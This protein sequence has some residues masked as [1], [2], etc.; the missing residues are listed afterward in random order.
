MKRISAIL[1]L[2]STQSHAITLGDAISTVVNDTSASISNELIVENEAYNSNIVASKQS[3]SQYAP[4]PYL[5]YSYSTPLST[6]LNGSLPAGFNFPTKFITGLTQENYGF[7]V[8][9]NI[10]SLPQAVRKIQSI[11][12][13]R[14][15]AKN[16]MEGKKA[17]FYYNLANVYI[18]LYR[19]EEI[20]ILQ[21]KIYE[22]AKARAIEIQKN[23]QYGMASKKDSLLSE[24]EILQAEMNLENYQNILKNAQAKYQEKFK[25][26]HAGLELVETPLFQIA[27]NVDELKEKIT[28]NQNVIALNQTAKSYKIESGIEKLNLLPKVTI[29][30]RNMFNNPDSSLG[31]PNYMQST[32]AVNANFNLLNI[33]NYYG[34]KKNSHESKKKFAEAKIVKASYEIEATNLWNDTRHQEELILVLTKVVNNAREIYSIT[35]NEVRSGTKSFTE[36]LRT[37]QEYHTA[38]LNLIEAKLKKM[39]NI[40][41]LKFLTGMSAF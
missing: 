7:A 15:A 32:F 3:I 18:E 6:Q 4:V 23:A 25:T 9:Y 28:Q 20:L 30:Y 13:V 21:K 26:L 34:S 35:K 14:S 22:T 10:A 2:L 37:K 38:E 31:F 12:V 17:E 24:S 36:E 16:S 27:K 8:D 1:L 19:A 29:T 39:Q 11:G 33:T 40:Q 5:F 41:R